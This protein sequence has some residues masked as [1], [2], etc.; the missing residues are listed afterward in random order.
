[1]IC[2]L[3]F[4]Y[5]REPYTITKC[6]HTFCKSCL[7]YSFVCGK[8]SCPTCDTYLGTDLHKVALPDR[9]LQDLIDKVLFP[10]LVEEDEAL[11]EQFYASLGISMKPEALALLRD[12]H[13]KR[14]RQPSVAP[15]MEE[16]APTPP[17]PSA[18]P[19]SMDPDDVIFQLLPEP[20]VMSN[21][22]AASSSNTTSSLVEATAAAVLPRLDLPFLQTKGD[23]RIEHLKKYLA[24][25]LF[26]QEQQ[27]QQ[28]HSKKFD[29]L[30][31]SVPLGDELS[32]TF[33]SRTVWDS[34]SEMVLNYRAGK[35]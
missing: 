19:A 17:S 5:Y 11:E 23:I 9:T 20:A 33:V 21:S 18:P 15:F 7:F 2:E 10:Q 22:N 34:S 29:I 14:K 24:L 4:G 27:Q 16:K 1:M 28:Q 6:L 30:C 13:R 25:K 35:V 12:I 3:C 32:L 8:Y 26:P 31:N